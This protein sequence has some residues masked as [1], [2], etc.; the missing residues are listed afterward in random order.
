MALLSL[1]ELREVV[2]ASRHRHM[3]HRD[4]VG[5]VECGDCGRMLLDLFTGQLAYDWN[6]CPKNMPPPKPHTGGEYAICNTE[7]ECKWK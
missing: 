4:H 2:R 5:V 3:I 7:E 1:N 6:V